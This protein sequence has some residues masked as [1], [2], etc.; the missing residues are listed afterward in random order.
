MTANSKAKL[1]TLYV[2]RMLMEET[3]EECGLTM[4]DIIDRLAEL[5]IPAERKGIY[6]DI[7][8]LREFGLDIQT[9][10]RAPVQYAIARRD[11]DLKD[12]TLMVDAVSSCKFLTR[13]QSDVLIGNIKSLASSH[14]QEQLDRTVHVPGRVNAE[15]GDVLAA[16]DVVHQAL[17]CRVKLSFGYERYGADGR[18][19]E[20]HDKDRLVTP[21]GVTYDGGFYYLTAWD[22]ENGEL[23]EFRIDRMKRLMVHD[24]PA[25]VNEEITSH[26]FDEDGAYEYFGRFG[27][28]RALVTFA[29]QS[30]RVGI[31]RDRFGEHVKIRP[32]GDGALA[33]AWVRVSP[34]FFGWVAGLEGKVTIAG[35]A[36]IKERYRAYLRE[37]LEE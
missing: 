4:A 28:D 29:V 20:T 36:D 34:Q 14:Q 30:D 23:R 16:L 24:E 6:R 7:Q 8:N 27:G 19:H 17:R 33:E 5:G 18:R 21:V 32:D 35:P 11:F 13:Q 25:T 12:L 3:D 26:V 37:L 15:V 2:M 1:K 9:Y 22:E 10:Q 31:V